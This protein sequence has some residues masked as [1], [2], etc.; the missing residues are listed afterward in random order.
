MHLHILQLF[1]KTLHPIFDR[2]RISKGT[3][4]GGYTSSPASW[5]H[6]MPTMIQEFRVEVSQKD[7]KTD[8]F[9][10]RAVSVYY[11]LHFLVTKCLSP[12][13]EYTDLLILAMQHIN[14]HTGES[15]EEWQTEISIF[16]FL[17]FYIFSLVSPSR[18]PL[19]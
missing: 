15:E 3:V 9:A 17:S 16:C 18:G 5:P 12:I 10:S 2:Y 14:V 4:P 13:A 1:Q 11:A 19:R 6:T 8:E 7:F